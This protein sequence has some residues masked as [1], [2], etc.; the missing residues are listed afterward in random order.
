MPAPT[1]ATSARRS[2]T[3][4]GEGALIAYVSVY[5]GPEPPSGGVRRPPRAVIAPHWTQL[6]GV[7]FTSTVPSPSSSPTSYTWAGHIQAHISATSRGTL[8]SIRTWFG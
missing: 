1:T 5:S 2:P 4:G 8:R 6:D 3:D 7:S